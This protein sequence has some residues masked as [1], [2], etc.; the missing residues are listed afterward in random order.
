MI[1]IPVQ[2]VDCSFSGVKLYLNDSD[3]VNLDSSGFYGFSKVS[4]VILSVAKNL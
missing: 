1:A 4:F 3:S 2:G